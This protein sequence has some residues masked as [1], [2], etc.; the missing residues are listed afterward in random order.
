MKRLYRDAGRSLLLILLIACAAAIAGLGATVHLFTL[1]QT[2]AVED[3]VITMAVR[4]VGSRATVAYDVRKDVQMLE[5]LN[6]HESVKIPA[7]I[8]AYAGIDADV[9]PVYSGNVDL[10]NWSRDRAHAHTVM[11]VTCLEDLGLEKDTNAWYYLVQVDE[12]HL[13]LP[14]DIPD[15]IRVERISSGSRAQEPLIPGE[16][17][18]LC[19]RYEDYFMDLDMSA[20][21]IMGYYDP[22]YK[23]DKS[24]LPRLRLMDW[25]D[26]N[27]YMKY[28]TTPDDTQWLAEAVRMGD[29][30]N[31]MLRLNCINDLSRLR[32]FQNGTASI[33]EGRSFT[34]EEQDSGAQVCLISKELADANGLTVGDTITMNANQ[35]GISLDI[36]S[37]RYEDTL[38]EYYAFTNVVD[39]PNDDYYDFRGVDVALEIVGIYSAPLYTNTIDEFTPNTVFAPY[40]AVQLEYNFLIRRLPI[41]TQNLIL[42]NGQGE[43][44]LQAVRDAGYPDGLYTIEETNYDEVRQVL[45]LMAADSITLFA[46]SAVVGLLMLVIILALYARSWRKENA[47][48][49]MLGTNRL[50]VTL[51][52]LLC[53]TVLVI[54]GCT[55][56][57]AAIAGAREYISSALNEVYITSSMDFSAIRVSAFSEKGMRVELLPVLLAMGLTCGAFLLVTTVQAAIA[58]LRTPRKGLFD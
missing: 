48:L 1:Q 8:R 4:H 53:C 43:A 57:L 10:Y 24:D 49:V 18:L 39:L 47:I 14:Y 11:T 2:H 45:A 38:S 7:L 40:N 56:A 22:V 31:R 6:G 21:L 33:V 44:F 16:T 29:M 20:S 17:Y 50:R 37:G 26:L 9:T 41:H 46:V 28:I 35:P 55:L 36:W 32:W 15:V 51:R 13:E 3:S 12:I 52:M 34:Q 58:A 25:W 42:H 27:D 30:N 54:A 5:F 23:P 19:G